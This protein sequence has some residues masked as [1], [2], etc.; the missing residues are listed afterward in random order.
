MVVSLPI[1]VL[2]ARSFTGVLLRKR[3]LLVLVLI[4]IASEA[5]IGRTKSDDRQPSAP[6]LGDDLVCWIVR[7]RDEPLRLENRVDL[8]PLR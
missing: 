5:F 4:L 8:C 7:L 3:R 2:L 6:E 1:L